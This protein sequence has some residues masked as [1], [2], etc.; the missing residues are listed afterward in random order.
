MTSQERVLT[1]LRRRQ[2]DRVPATLYDEVIAY[3]PDVARM[4]D[5]KCGGQWPG[6]YFACD[7]RSVTIGPTR[8]K[9]DFSKHIALQADTSIDEWGVGRRAGG[10]HHYTQFIYPLQS[11]DA[12]AIRDY[13]FPDV[14]ADYRYNGLSVTVAALHERGLAVTGYPGSVFEQA[15]QMRGMAEL[16]GDIAEDP[17]TAEFLL[18]QIADRVAGAA[19]RLAAAGIDVLILGDDIATQRGLMM[20]LAMWKRFFKPRL[21]RII[22]AAKEVKPDVIIFYHS[23]GNV[24]DAVAELID[25]GVEVLN[26][27]QPECMDPAEVKRVFGHRLAFF[28][29]VSVQRTMP[30][31]TPDEVR[32]EVKHR[33]ETVGRGGGL[34]LSPAHVLQPDV[35]WEN[36][37]AFFEA[38]EQYG[39][40]V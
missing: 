9:T 3:V 16:F 37:V 33:I 4:L 10:F 39:S 32:A 34:L 14:D 5:E 12:K 8:L 38:V 23:D 35:P 2:P 20:S 28:G 19:Q 1:A 40:S 11:L 7:V 27:V 25:A 26:P 31:G 36:I 6:D 30:F 17:D 21:Q 24:W 13:P 29:T 22:R 15:W 18:D